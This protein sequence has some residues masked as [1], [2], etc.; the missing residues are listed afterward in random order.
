MLSN[1]PDGVIARLRTGIPSG[2]PKSVRLHK[3]RRLEPMQILGKMETSRSSQVHCD[4][5][6]P[7]TAQQEILFRR[8]FRVKGKRP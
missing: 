4:G 6:K 3:K 7:A 5:E 8:T 2:I 1:R